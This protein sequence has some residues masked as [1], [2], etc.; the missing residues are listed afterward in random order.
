MI[1]IKKSSFD[2][3]NKRLKWKES[4]LY[5]YLY[6]KRLWVQQNEWINT[7]YEIPL[8]L[9]FNKQKK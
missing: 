4:H 1:R 5:N 8:I 3:K 9:I 7:E 2:G 6:I